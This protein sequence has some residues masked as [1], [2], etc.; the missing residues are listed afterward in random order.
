M[1]DA[2]APVMRSNEPLAD[3][4]Q[5]ISRAS[6]LLVVCDFDGTISEH[7]A[8][9]AR[10]TADSQGLQAIV[11]LACLPSTAVAVVS[12]RCLAS[13]F[14]CIPVHPRVAYIGSHGAEWVKA[15][16]NINDGEWVSQAEALNKIVAPALPSNAREL[17]D[18]M[19]NNVTAVVQE[20]QG[21]FVEMKRYGI[22]VHVRGVDPHQQTEILRRVQ[23]ALLVAGAVR[24]C[25][26]KQVVE[27]AVV[28]STKGDVIKTLRKD[29]TTRVFVI[30]DDTT[31]EDAFIVAQQGDCSIKVG[32]GHTLAQYRVHDVREACAALFAVAV[33]R[34]VWH[35]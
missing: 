10:A 34:K 23:H 9:P 29:D 21:V 7:V 35:E 8:L 15:S 32:P 24:I 19:R 20:F 31:D 5:S 17:L 26:G 2:L 12:G 11:Q 16:S 28:D 30:G 33:C 18:R 1:H 25:L 3:A 13:L 27:G 4:I 6:S 14:E 22:A